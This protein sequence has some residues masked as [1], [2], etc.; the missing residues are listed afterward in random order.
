MAEAR[1]AAEKARSA[2]AHLLLWT[3]V[4]LLIGAFC[5]S[6]AAT[7]GGRQRDHMKLA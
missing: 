6:F 7:M 1:E 2:T 5:A 3:F 4:A